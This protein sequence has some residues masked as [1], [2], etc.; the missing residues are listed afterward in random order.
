M[1]PAQFD[2]GWDQLRAL[3]LSTPPWAIQRRIADFLDSET[4][5]VDTLIA[6]K[7]RMITLSTVR[8]ESWRERVMVADEDVIWTPLHHLTDPRRPIVYGIVQAGDEV[9]DGIPYIKTGDVASLRPDRLSRTSPEIDHAYR[10]ARVRPGDI[11]IAMRASIGLPVVI[12]PELPIANLTQGTARVASRH[13][14]DSSWLF[15]ALKC[16]AVQEQCEVQAVGTTFKTL[17]IWDLRRIKIPTPSTARQ[18]AVGRR[19]EQGEMQLDALIRRLN[20]QIELFG[21]HRQAL[22]TAAVTGEL[23][24]A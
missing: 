24:V 10:R 17:N 6:N 21:E 9:P 19:I 22:I 11:V 23:D 1:P 13:D 12:P 15:H 3:P 2:I 18:R 7:R 5:R 4:A 14:V 20:R 16:R 8:Y